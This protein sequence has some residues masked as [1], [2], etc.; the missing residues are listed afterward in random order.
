MTTAPIAILGGGPVGLTLALLLARHRVPA[1]VVDA[2]DLDEAR[3]DRRLLALSR[4]TLDTLGTVVDL[5]ATALAP[6]RTVVVSSRGE[7][8]RAVLDE[9]DHGGRALGATV[10]YGEL[11]AALDTACMAAPLVQLRRRCAATSVRQRANAAEVCLAEGDT[12]TAPLAVNAEGARPSDRASAVRQCALT[13][14]VEVRGPA[15]GTA[16]ERFTRDGPLAL[17]P[18]PGPAAVAVRPMSLVW[19]MPTATA[20]RREALSDADLLAELQAELGERTAR[21]ISIR[22]RGRH[23]LVEQARDDVREH[24]LVHVGNAA[25]TLHPVAGQGLNLGVRDCVALA[26]VV[27]AAMAVAEDPVVR[28]PEYERRRRLDRLAIRTLTRTV[29]GFFAT[30]FAPVA[31]ARSAGLTLL[32]IFPDLRAEFARFLMFGVRS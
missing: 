19:C 9:R 18:L 7:F 13:G 15:A 12:L 25:Q 3:R 21:V 26:D 1:V 5:P 32:S 24:R 4:G 11:L 23:A 29:P 16:F 2:R 27:G 22:T 31:A 6:I 8:G 30:G 10:R 17:L 28:L 20:D 14:D